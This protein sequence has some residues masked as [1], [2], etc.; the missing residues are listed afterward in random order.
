MK[1]IVCCILIGLLLGAACA[2]ADSGSWVCP[3]CGQAGNTGNF[4]SNCACPRPNEGWL[5]PQCG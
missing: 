3:Q 4:C 2:L 1:R 5:C